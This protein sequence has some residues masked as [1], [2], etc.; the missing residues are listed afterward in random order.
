MLHLKKKT[1][2]PSCLGTS[3]W[4][5]RLWQWPV[6]HWGA[7]RWLMIADA[8][9]SIWFVTCTGTE[10]W[11]KAR[12]LQERK[13]FSSPLGSFPSNYPV[14]VILPCPEAGSG[15]LGYLC[16]RSEGFPQNRRSD[17]SDSREILRDQRLGWAQKWAKRSQRRPGIDLNTHTHPS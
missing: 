17:R 8:P 13:K 5:W 12:R 15:G 3:S 2:H 10:R 6:S 11:E 9:C 1:V 4:L 16:S 7:S 14:P